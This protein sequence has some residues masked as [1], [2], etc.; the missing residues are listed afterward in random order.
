VIVCS[1]NVLSDAQVRSAIA[2]APRS[3]MSSVYTSLGCGAKCGRCAHTVKIMLEEARVWRLSYR[4][5]LAK[6]K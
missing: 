3:R 4:D 5:I 2:S 6:R 1:C